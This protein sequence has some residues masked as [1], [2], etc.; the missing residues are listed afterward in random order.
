MT[1]GSSV[2]GSV[3]T[4]C[5]LVVKCDALSPHSAMNVTC[6]WQARAMPQLLTMPFEYAKRTTFNHMVGGYAGAPVAS[7][8]KRKSKWDR[9]IA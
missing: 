3:M 5:A 1:L 4:N 6:S 8:R 7:F 9:S 2:V